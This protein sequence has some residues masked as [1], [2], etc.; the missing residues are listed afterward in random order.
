MSIEGIN[1]AGKTTQS[2]LLCRI[3]RN[4][5]YPVRLFKFPNYETKVGELIRNT[6]YKHRDMNSRLL[7]ALF[8]A[9]RLES[10]DDI[11]KCL[12]SGEVAVSDRY[13]DSEYAYGV[14]QGLPRQWLLALE[15]QMP[16][17]DLVILLDMDPSLALTRIGP[18]K[19]S[20]IF[21]EN[22]GL[23]SRV[24]QCYLDLANKPPRPGQRWEIIDAKQDTGTVHEIVVAKVLEVLSDTIAS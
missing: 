17:A 6:L 21:E 10:R 19:K 15:S 7:S 23:L 5:G 11:L 4:Q 2:N 14:A 24:R 9:N 20:D 18:D 22:P 3:L 1:R 13:A 8:S 12:S 16:C